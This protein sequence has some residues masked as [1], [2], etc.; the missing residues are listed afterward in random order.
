VK[1]KFETFLTEKGIT[2]EE[3]GKKSADEQSELWA[4]FIEVQIKA[5]SELV[6]KKASKEEIAELIREKDE[7][8]AEEMKAIK[9]A[10]KEQGEAM[11]SMS[12][13][14]VSSSA[15]P[16]SEIEVALE[17]K[18]ESFKKE[19]GEKK[20]SVEFE[21]KTDVTAASITNST[22]AMRLDSIGQLAHSK[23]T[24]RDLFTVIPVGADSNGVIRYSDWDAATTVRAAAMVA[25][26]A[27][28]TESTAV[29]E[30]FTLELKKIGDTIPLSE[31]TIYDRPRFAREINQ[32][33][34]VNIAI[35]EDNQL[36]MGGGGA[37]MD[38]LY[39]T[40]PTYTAA[41]S[42]IASPS[43]YDLIV[44]MREAIMG[45]YGSKY[46]PNFAMMNI[47][48]ITSMQLT[49]DA[50]DNYVMPPFADEQ[51]NVIMNMVVIENSNIANNT[52]VIG[53]SRYGTIYEVEGTTI[54]TG[55]VGNNFGKD[56][57]TMKGRKREALLL[58]NVDRTGFLKC[59]DIAAAKVTLAT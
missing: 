1:K 53:D 28:Y 46:S 40:A 14:L 39:P 24:L 41:A 29:W 8:R 25:E 34:S 38:G 23:L 21:I 33:L 54:M 32:F 15:N 43:T 58:R 11:K 9:A 45:A 22:G 13:K 49:K 30:E 42:G 36:A 27:L 26:G 37:N 51:G 6:E 5:Q 19:I 12:M 50:N 57:V 18:A 48:E 31:E 3:F 55:Y 10:M 35:V 7:A 20:G 52:C 59:T 16:K 56:L 2:S 17:E 47:S 4:D 44:K